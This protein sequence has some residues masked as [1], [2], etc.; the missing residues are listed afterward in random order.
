P[1]ERSLAFDVRIF[2]RHPPLPGVPSLFAVSLEAA[3]K[4]NV[5]RCLDPDRVRQIG[6]ERI[7][8]SADALE[9]DEPARIDDELV[10]GCAVPAR[11]RV[12]RGT[13]VRQWLEH[14]LDER[15]PPV[16][17]VLPARELVRVDD[18]CLEPTSETCR[19]AGLSGAAEAVDR[20]DAGRD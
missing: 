16:E 9:Q 4:A 20:D 6:A 19:E 15:R 2:V 3:A 5:P 10:L 11:R 18:R 12:P 7:P 14:A 13:S 8:R 1:L 17:R